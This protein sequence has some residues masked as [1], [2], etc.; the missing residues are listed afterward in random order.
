MRKYLA[1][2]ATGA[3]LAA[4]S[5][6]AVNAA[7]FTVDVTATVFASV[8][9]YAGDLVVGTGLVGSISLTTDEGA[10]SFAD[11]TPSTVP[12]H[13]YTSF[14]GFDSPPFSWTGSAPS[15]G[16]PGFTA[17]TLGIV[18]NNNLTLTAAETGGLFA[19]GT[20]D[21]I[22]LLGSTTIDVCPPG[23]TCPFPD[24]FTPGD[25]EEWTLAIVADSTWFTDGSVIPDALPGT[26]TP[27]LIG[28]DFDA[29]GNEVGVVI[30]TVDTF[31]TTLPTLPTAQIHAPATATLGGLLFLIGYM[32]R[33]RRR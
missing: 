19:D 15:L 25:G 16:P 17:D 33:R 29:D 3:L 11:P 10:A 30:A 4:A 26:F 21:W 20:Y 2:L 7:P 13:E 24:P 8:G 22:E 18:V 14:Y 23:L 27:V 32:G 5:Q 9:T 1:T 31:E 12:G 28:N 6:P